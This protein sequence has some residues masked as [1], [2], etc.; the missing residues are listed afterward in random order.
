MEKSYLFVIRRDENI[1]LYHPLLP[2]P[3]SDGSALVLEIGMLEREADKQ[4]IIAQMKRCCTR[5]RQRLSVHVSDNAP[6]PGGTCRPYSDLTSN[7]RVL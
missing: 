4:G 2:A 5:Q 7:M 6:P 1:V 3:P